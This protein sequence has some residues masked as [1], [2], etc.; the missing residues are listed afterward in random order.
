MNECISIIVP[1]Y[2]VE[3]YLDECIQS[4]IN[5]TYSNLEIILIDDG[6]TDSSSKMCDC[7]ANQDSRIKVI[8][9]KNAGLSAARNIGTN[10]ATGQYITYIDS[11]DYIA[12]DYIECLYEMI[13]KY[14]ADIAICRFR[15]VYGTNEEDV[16]GKEAIFS[17]NKTEALRTLLLE[18]EF[19][20][21]TH[22][23]LFKKE[24]VQQYPFPVGKIYEDIATT[25]LYFDA[26]NTIV[27]SQKQ[28]YYYRQR[29]GSIITGAYN[30]KNKFDVL[31]T[32]DSME[33]FLRK[34]HPDLVSY[35]IVP[36]MFYYLHTYARLPEDSSSYLEE[37]EKVKKYIKNNRANALRFPNMPKST[38]KKILL[39]YM[40]GKIYRKVWKLQKEQLAKKMEIQ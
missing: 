38:K 31:N 29:P 34:K 37:Q 15:Y 36:K 18:N 4:I 8:H 40:G 7:Y 5:Q 32:L 3:Q 10:M 22:Q 11:D 27:Y 13:E 12:K 39:S 23:K 24:I 25:Y 30:E 6:S 20:H 17:Y 28:L 35:M 9:Q 2:N 21:Y 19:G 14:N 1:V 16:D 33:E 26:A